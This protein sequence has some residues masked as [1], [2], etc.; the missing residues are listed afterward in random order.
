MPGFD[1]EAGQAISF[2]AEAARSLLDEAGYAEGQ[3]LPDIVLTTVGVDIGQIS[4]E[5]VQGQ[6]KENLDID[7]QVE[8][9]DPP[10]Y[11]MRYGSG[12]FQMTVGGWN[13]D[14]PHPENWI[15]DLFH[16]GNPFG[17]SNSKVDDLIDQAVAEKDPV[18]AVDVYK[19]AQRII[20]DEDGALAPIFHRIAAFLVKPYV[21]GLV[22]T[23]TDG[24]VR[25]DLFLGSPDVS[26][27]AH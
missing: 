2:D 20:L 14:Y 3:G 21:R 17:Y 8:V 10:T 24:E 4:A 7:V 11:Q 18:A 27:A 22:Y 19:Q 16:T 1:P 26:I 25:G 23:V 9:L 5:F 13:G 12:E 6:L 15:R